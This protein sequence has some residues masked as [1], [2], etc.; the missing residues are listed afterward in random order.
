MKL[1]GAARLAPAGIRTTRGWL[2]DALDG[3]PVAFT[4]SALGAHGSRGP[5]LDTEQ[6]ELT[7]AIL[8]RRQPTEHTATSA[9]ALQRRVLRE[10]PGDRTRRARLQVEAR[11]RRTIQCVICIRRASQIVL[12]YPPPPEAAFNARQDSNV[13]TIDLSMRGSSISH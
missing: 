8:T 2:S 7:R 10:G 11:G 9:A 5:G 3:Q 4:R 1:I 13:A 12:E 6:V